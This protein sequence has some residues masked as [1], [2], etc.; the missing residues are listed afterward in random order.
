VPSVVKTF[1]AHPCTEAFFRR[2]EI[3]PVHK[4]VRRDVTRY[5]S[6]DSRAKQIADGESYH[7]GNAGEE[8]RGGGRLTILDEKARGAHRKP[9]AEVILR[10]TPLRATSSVLC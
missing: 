7:R 4:C 10:S 9:L 6:P 2:R 1:L 5:V 8:M 3:S